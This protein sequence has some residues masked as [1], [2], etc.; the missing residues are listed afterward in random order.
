VEAAETSQV[1]SSKPEPQSENAWSPAWQIFVDWLFLPN[2]LLGWTR[3][4]TGLSALLILMVVWVWSHGGP[5]PVNIPAWRIGPHLINLPLPPEPFNQ[6]AFFMAGVAGLAMIVGFK[7]KIW[8]LILAAVIG[9]WGASDWVACG[10]HFIILEWIA[11]IAFLFERADRSATRRIIQV[12]TVICYL[13]TGWQK[14]LFPDFR[15]GYSFEAMFADGWSLGSVWRGVIPVERFGHEFWWFVSWATIIVELLFAFGLC[16]P[17]TRK[18]TA[19]VAILF[20]LSIAVFLDKFIAIFSVVMWAGLTTFFDRKEKNVE[21]AVHVKRDAANFPIVPLT[22]LSN[23][24]ASLSAI[25]LA[26]LVIFP[27]RVYF[28]PGRPVDKLAFFDRSPWSFCMYLA[29]QETTRLEAKYQDKSGQWHEHTI[30]RV[31]RWGGISSDNETYAL[32]S[33]IFKV[34]PDA[35]RVRI[36]TDILLNGRLPQEKVFERDRND[37]SQEISVHFSPPR[38]EMRFGLRNYTAGL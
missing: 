21:G 12:S 35:Q 37:D 15:D 22:R 28:Y 8:P 6:I 38:T 26:V 34:H 10:C 13:Y 16:F 4:L 32:A 25:L 24:Q 30:H 5:G 31:D 17:K 7:N 3:R 27:L 9:Y 2:A 19:I 29:R 33:Y 18:I 1:N 14:M 23:I 36:E 20:H 11:L